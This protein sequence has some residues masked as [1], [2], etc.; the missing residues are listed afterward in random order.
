MLLFRHFSSHSFKISL[1]LP[2]NC[3]DVN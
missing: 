1:S 3:S 2:V